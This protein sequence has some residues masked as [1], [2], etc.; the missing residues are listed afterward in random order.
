MKKN[1]FEA[2]GMILQVLKIIANFQITPPLVKLERTS[3][4]NIIP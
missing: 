3:M 4:I 1:E 2:E